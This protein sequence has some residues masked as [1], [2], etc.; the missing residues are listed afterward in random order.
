MQL[1]GFFAC[2]FFGYLLAIVLQPLI[3]SAKTSPCEPTDFEK[4][5][6]SSHEIAL[7]EE[8]ELDKSPY[9]YACQQR[10]DLYK[11]PTFRSIFSDLN[12][13]DKYGNTS[14]GFMK[15]LSAAV[16]R[17]AD[18]KISTLDG[19]EK[20]LTIKKQAPECSETLKSLNTDV[21]NYLALARYH[22]SMAVDPTSSPNASTTRPNTRLKDLTSY[23]EF[24]WS[25]L[26]AD[27]Q[28]VAQADIKDYFS[29]ASA[30]TNPKLKKYDQMKE[31]LRKVQIIR[32]RH[33]DA[34]QMM[35]SEFPL[36]NYLNKANP[37]ESEVLSAIRI[38][39][40]RAVKEYVKLFKAQ[41]SLDSGVTS[42]SFLFL[43]YKSVL[44]GL[45]LKNPTYCGL[46]VSLMKIRNDRQH[47]VGTM[48]GF[49][50]M[51]ATLLA[52]P[53]IPGTAG[54]MIS[55]G[56]GGIAGVGYAMDAQLSLDDARQ[57]ITSQYKNSFGQDI[58]DT[59]ARITE[60]QESISS[61]SAQIKKLEIQM[62]SAT[63][64]DKKIAITQQIKVETKALALKKKA[65]D[66]MLTS[67]QELTRL[68]D[69][70][71][72]SVAAVPLIEATP[73]LSKGLSKALT[74]IRKLSSHVPG[75]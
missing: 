49:P 35:L 60:I 21:P 16:M 67:N 29:Q 13:E 50:L 5:V 75:K 45:L 39:K 59:T 11:P 73:F 41:K 12:I 69:D 18:E 34:Y 70:R 38:M 47:A 4:F 51:A 61:K 30:T 32:G 22:L 63:S 36:M 54:I 56:I 66:A 25:P 28:T 19:L 46:S 43:N 40:A 8:K 58:G 55:M 17:Y 65:L 7:K 53:L 33:M 44:E 71:D 6:K 68:K 48:V 42:D 37:S 27:E 52:P 1:R 10:Y 9:H 2:H 24:S 23:K 57:R 72:F 31:T 74:G 20:C 64:D 26:T 62:Q 15:E 3:S 14:L